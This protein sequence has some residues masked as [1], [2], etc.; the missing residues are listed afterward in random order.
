MGEESA[1]ECINVYEVR[2]MWPQTFR[3]GMALLQMQDE[4][5][6]MR[7]REATEAI[8]ERQDMPTWKTAETCHDQCAVPYQRMMGFGFTKTL[9]SR[10]M[11]WLRKVHLKLLRSTVDPLSDNVPEW[12]RRRVFLNCYIKKPSLCLRH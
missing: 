3:L 6:Q 9:L 5:V 2:S 8:V 7:M 4:D 10:T 1:P 12:K 11:V